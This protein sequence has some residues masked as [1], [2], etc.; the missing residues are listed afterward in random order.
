MDRWGRTNIMMLILY[1]LKI[2]NVFKESN[3]F[4]NLDKISVSTKFQAISGSLN[5]WPKSTGVDLR[6]MMKPLYY[7]KICNWSEWVFLHKWFFEQ[8]LT[9]NTL[10]K[11][12]KFYTISKSVKIFVC[13]N[14]CSTHQNKCF[15]TIHPISGNLK[16]WRKKTTTR[17]VWTWQKW[18]K[19]CTISTYVDFC[20]FDSLRPTTNLSVKQGRVFLGWTVLS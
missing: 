3:L 14:I 10:L 2:Y 19:L 8:K 20:L 5:F 9:A 13:N 4:V 12:R 11:S 15:Y 16:Y 18:L 6:K 7:L 17:Q 1:C